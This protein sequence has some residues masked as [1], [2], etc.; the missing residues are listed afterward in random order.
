MKALTKIYY[1]VSGNGN[2]LEASDSAGGWEDQGIS[3]IE[4]LK[5]AHGVSNKKFRIGHSICTF[6]FKTL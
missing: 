6:K 2:I 3:N 5:V 4:V 1:L